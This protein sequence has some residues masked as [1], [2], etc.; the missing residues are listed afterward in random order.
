MHGFEVLA[1]QVGAAPLQL[2]LAWQVRVALPLRVKLA[3]HAYVAV[4]PK[5]VDEDGEVA[6]V[7]FVI[8]PRLPQSTGVL[9]VVPLYPVPVQLQV[10]F[11]PEP[12]VHVPP[13]WQGALEHGLATATQVGDEPL[14]WP[15]PPQVRVALPFSTK[16][17]SHSYWALPPGR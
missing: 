15:L 13:C 9:Q 17:V 10:K 12:G 2:P 14:H 4:V 3:L 6:M 11:E 8:V 16:P 1:T 7:P 5:V